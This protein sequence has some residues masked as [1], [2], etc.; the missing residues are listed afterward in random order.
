MEKRGAMRKIFLTVFFLVIL[1][2]TLFYFGIYG[3]GINSF[4]K[5]GISGFAIGKTNIFEELKTNYQNLSGTSK[6]VIMGEWLIIIFVFLFILIKGLVKGRVNIQ[7]EIVG[8]AAI[9]KEPKQKPR[10]DLDVFYDTLKQKKSLR[11][12]VAAK[13]FNISKEEAMTWGKILESGKFA[14]I[15]YPA[16]GDPKI[17]L[18]GGEKDEKKEPKEKGN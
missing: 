5:T 11:V 7:K 10:T 13:L 3:T 17:V 6:I 16:V 8:V 1:L 12:S 14:E 4:A 15:H 18:I 2:Q 9:I